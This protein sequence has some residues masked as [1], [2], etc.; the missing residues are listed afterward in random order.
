MS[1]EISDTE[2]NLL[3]LYYQFADQQGNVDIEGAARWIYDRLGIIV[4]RKPFKITGE[5]LDAL[6]KAKLLPDTRPLFERLMKKSGS[7]EQ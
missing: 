7:E 1:S 3:L 5:H 4:Q 2:L 6:I